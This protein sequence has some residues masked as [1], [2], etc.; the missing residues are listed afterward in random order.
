M[1]RMLSPRLPEV[2]AVADNL[3]GT[4]RTLPENGIVQV[5]GAPSAGKT[6]LLHQVAQRLLDQKS[7]GL[8]PILLSPPTGQRDTAFAGFAEAAADLHRRS[9]INGEFEALVSSAAPWTWADSLATFRRWLKDKPQVVL[10]C[11]EP[12][13]WV[14]QT[15]E[16][17]HY[18]QFA[19]ELATFVLDAPCRKLVVGASYL[20]NAAVTT[21][22]A[23]RSE[24]TQWLANGE[25]WGLLASAAERV[26][27]WNV[28][29]LGSCSPLTIRLLVALTQ[30][31]DENGAR[32]WLGS[33]GNSFRDLT[34][35]VRA[36]LSKSSVY[37]SV[38][39]V[40]DA[41]ALLRRPFGSEFL[42]VSGSDALS[43]EARALLDHC[44][45]Y[46][47]ATPA[48]RWVL[49]DFLRSAAETPAEGNLQA[50]HARFA[51]TYHSAFAAS[52]V[53]DHVVAEVEAFH[54]ATTSSDATTLSELRPMFV[55]QLQLLGRELSVRGRRLQLGQ[56]RVAAKDH[57]TRSV[58]AY[59]NALKWREDA[60]THHFLGFNL[61]ALA[62]SAPEAE[63]HYREAIRL[64]PANARWHSMLVQFLIDRSR[65]DDARAAWA[66]AIDSLST[67]LGDPAIYFELHLYAARAWM[68]RSQLSDARKALDAIPKSIDRTELR[69][70]RARLEGLEEAEGGRAY[71]PLRFLRK[72]W[73]AN[74][75]FLLSRGAS[76]KP[77]VRWLAARVEAADKE[78]VSL[79]V[80]SLE[81]G[82]KKVAK[83]MSL[84]LE[85]RELR[86]VCKDDS[87]SRFRRGQFLE[88]GYYGTDKQPTVGRFHRDDA[89]EDVLPPPFPP[90]DRYLKSES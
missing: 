82:S 53:E 30:S 22:L 5:V 66:R 46:Q 26:N 42:A 16:V 1:A 44:V 10:L 31:G 40:W 55:E 11:D 83:T 14:R 35:R 52:S 57:F 18:D 17:D 76:N 80:A 86:R 23:P 28:N 69:A 15:T 12:G 13:N 84:V 77:L 65:F 29:R 33:E 67:Q 7:H 39:A 36:A 59:R 87:P 89:E 3:V 20:H 90:Y 38:N 41:L 79:R 9:V 24:P 62:T 61:D 6:A 32:A 8:I 54:H 48:A 50:M 60:Y 2:D 75:P 74:G 27:R 63:R 47:E 34:G 70:V 49:H 58:D 43:E 21:N 64:D 4:L 51:R 85:E 56:K 25:E 68:H 78:T 73:A 37:G 19:R 88:L 72:G 45:L 71:V 81:A